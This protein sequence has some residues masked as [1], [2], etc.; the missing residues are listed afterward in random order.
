MKINFKT[1]GKYLSIRRMKS[2]FVTEVAG[3]DLPACARFFNDH[4]DLFKSQK[5]ALFLKK[6]LE[7]FDK[8]KF[9]LKIKC[10]RDIRPEEI[11]DEALRDYYAFFKRCSEI[12][13]KIELKNAKRQK[14]KD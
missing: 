3:N 4:K 13:D 14:D 9:D 1:L 6:V 7:G 12:Q 10:V 8:K 5:E 11:Y 2:T